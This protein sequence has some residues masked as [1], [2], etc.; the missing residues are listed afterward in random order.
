MF[1][2]INRIIEYG[3]EQGTI[4]VASIGNDGTNM[5][6]YSGY[7]LPGSNPGTI[8][9]A[10]LDDTDRRRHDSNYGDSA[11]T[12]AAPGDDIPVPVPTEFVSSGYS[13][14]SQTSAAAPQVAG[15]ASLLRELKPNLHPRLI[16]Q[17]IQQG[18]VEL[19]GDRTS[20]IGAGRID[21]PNT[22][23]RLTQ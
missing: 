1:A 4:T 2:A 12:V 6:K 18:A 22:I 15:L 23:D 9:V 10:A 5:N 11:V 20:G 21:V 3:I 19:T 17:A 16:T 14:F 13:Y 7:V 8:S